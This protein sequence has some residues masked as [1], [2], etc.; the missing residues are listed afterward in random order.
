MNPFVHVQN[1]AR[2]V[3]GAGR[4]AELAD[5]VD[6]FGAL[7][8]MTVAGEPEA[9]LLERAVDHLGQR[10][11]VSWNEVRQHVPSDLAERAADYASEHDADLIVTVGGGS[12]TGLAKAVVL[13][14]EVPILAVPTT[15]AGSEM[16]HIW[17]Q[18]RAGRKTTGRDRT[19]LPQTVIYD[20]ELTVTLPPHISGASGMNAM[21]HCVEAVYAPDASPITTSVALQAVESLSKGLPA[22]VA[23][24]GDLNARAD[25]QFGACLSGMVLATAG[26]G[27]HH[28]IC[29]VLGGMYDLPH[30]ELHTVVLPQAVAAVTAAAPEPVVQIG[31]ALEV[32]NAA[33]GL[34]D[35][36][37]SMDLPVSL[38]AIGMGTDQ[39]EAAIPRCVEATA[40]DVAGLTAETARKLLMSAVKGERP[41]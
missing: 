5:E 22:V 20:P 37:H 31:K 29:H 12:T 21:A 18:T 38:S 28:H 36:A 10:H 32:E 17:G 27:I 2:I 35:L 40:A 25:V 11:A 8:V 34:Y 7:R 3:F 26:I 15:Y 24:P 13:H 41:K 14:H 23:N 4:F 6:R 9:A 30:A 16:T 33:Q 19:V 1:P 39:I